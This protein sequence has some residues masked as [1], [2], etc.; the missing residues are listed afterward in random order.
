[1]LRII[2][3]SILVLSFI[4]T[5]YHHHYYL[6]SFPAAASAS[7]EPVLSYS[8]DDGMPSIIGDPALRV[9]EV[10]RGLDLPTTMAFL[11][12]NDILV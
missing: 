1:M 9:E 5:D 6:S 2:L 8:T 7:Y 11:G 4:S 12:P 10:V 3:L